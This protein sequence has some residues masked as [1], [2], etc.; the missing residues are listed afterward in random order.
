MNYQEVI[1]ET[2]AEL[3]KLEKETKDLKGRDRVRFLRLLKIGEATSQKQAGIMIG[4]QMRQS[5]RLWQKYQ[6]V[7]LAEF[8]KSHYEGRR[9]KLSESEKSILAERLKE[10]DV[11]SLQ[12]A[13]DYLA[14]EFGVSYTIG[15]VSYIFK[16]MR[17]KLKTGR[18]SNIKQAEAESQ[19]F[20]KNSG[21]GQKVSKAGLLGR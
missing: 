2:V 16:Q 4:L 8:I 21:F 11:M 6:A 17:V 9:S 5:Q 20:K 3:S 10:D 19:A 1:K 12:Q 15:G 18:P 14:D 7:G 13:Q